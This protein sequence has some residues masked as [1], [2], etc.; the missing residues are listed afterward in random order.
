MRIAFPLFSKARSGGMKVI[1]R[2]ADAACRSGHEVVLLVP[3]EKGAARAATLAKTLKVPP[4]PVLG[5]ISRVKTLADSF[6]FSKRLRGFDAILAT[7]AATSLST[8][9][10]GGKNVKRYY[11]VQHDENIFYSR[12]SFEYLVSRLS[13][14]AFEE[15]RVFAVS[16][17]LQD[18]VRR[19]GGPQPI[20]LPPGIDHGN[21][22]PRD[23]PPHEG[24]QVLVLVRDAK[25]RGL[26]FFF[27]AMESVKREVKDV[28]IIAAGGSGIRFETSCPIEYVRP[29]DDELARLYSSC[30]VYVLPS[31]IEG[32]GA[33]PLEAMACGGAVVTTD[34]LG[35]RDFAIDGVNCLVVPPSD[36]DALAQAIIK[37]LTNDGLSHRLRM[38]GPGTAAPWTY[39]RMEKIFLER[40]ESDYA[41][42]L[43]NGPP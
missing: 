7:H 32:L 38:N 1:L 14:T 16:R 22:Y 6:L 8:K 5:R 2:L 42:P 3:E 36:S 21:F 13:Y 24:K 30:D 15:G 19:R 25:W 43:A 17:W 34:C 9:L 41:E 4:F 12:V 20:L 26:Q 33:P 39:D 29:S 27:D 31:V 10:A 11:L 28:K 18:M 37:V 35:T 23:R 40:L